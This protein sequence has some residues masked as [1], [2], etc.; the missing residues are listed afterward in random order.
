MARARSSI[1]EG[2]RPSPA[3]Q[4][5]CEAEARSSKPASS[6]R[7]C[8]IALCAYAARRRALAAVTDAIA[9]RR[10]IIADS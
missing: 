3:P 1:V 7:V 4:S 5:I 2:P 8:F 10:P 6:V 9:K